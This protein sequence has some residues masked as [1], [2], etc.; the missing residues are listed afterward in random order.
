MA[1]RAELGKC[2][3]IFDIKKR[4]LNYLCNEGLIQFKIDLFF[5]N[6]HMLFRHN[7]L[8]SANSYS[9]ILKYHLKGNRFSANR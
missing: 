4:I 6:F 1:R 8:I 3:M 7:F 5:G 9:T 2:P